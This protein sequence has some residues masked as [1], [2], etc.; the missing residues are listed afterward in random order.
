MWLIWTA[1]A[2]AYSPENPDTQAFLSFAAGF[3]A[4]EPL[5][6]RA[7]GYA[8]TG[9]LWGQIAS[10]MKENPGL[11]RPEHLGWSVEERP[12]WA[13][14]LGAPGQSERRVMVVAQL[15]ALEW[16]GAQ[17]AL[18]L[19]NDFVAAPHSGVALVVVPVANPDGRARVEADLRTG[20]PKDTYR[21]A[22]T[23]LVDLNR[24]WAVNRE[25]DSWL[26]PRLP[27]TRN[28][29]SVSPGPLSQPETQA[30]DTL[31]ASFQPT[32]V[33]DLHAYGGYVLVPWAGRYEHTPDH[34][35]LMEKATGMSEAMPGRPYRAMQLCHWT[36][37]FRA[38]GAQI[39]HMYATYDADS[40]LIE[41]GNIG[42]RHLRQDTFRWYN[43]KDPR[44]DLDK[45]SAALWA[46]IRWETP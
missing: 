46:L 39:D 26:W 24:D 42:V 25:P 18:E 45:V 4:E 19:I 44:K 22:N 37:T 11:I 30:I 7:D 28:F 15:H 9:E 38:M 21:R 14:H 34:E 2:L 10:L 16:V 31:A 6:E 23:N 40:F 5:P 17:A 12:L 41:I 32:D 3:K 29:Y 1:A 36:R 43:P 8:S 13:M 20:A 27:I 33:V 35:R